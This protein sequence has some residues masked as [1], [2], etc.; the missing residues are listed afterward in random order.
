MSAAEQAI[1][2]LLGERGAGKSICPSEAARRLDAQDFRAHMHAVREAGRA[3][4]DRGVIEVTRKGRPVDPM[5]TGSVL[6]R[7]GETRL[8]PCV[9]PR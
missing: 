3:L 6:K 8:D 7:A 5:V 1:L 9:V 4:A 2:S